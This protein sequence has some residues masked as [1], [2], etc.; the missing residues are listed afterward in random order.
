M[1]PVA[2]DMV[3]E[4]RYAVVLVEA[5]PEIVVLRLIKTVPTE[6]HERVRPHHHGRMDQLVPDEEVELRTS[7]L[8]IDLVARLVDEHDAA[9][10]QRDLRMG[11]EIG[12]L[13]LEPIGK[14]DVVRVHASD[15]RRRA[16]AQPALIATARPPGC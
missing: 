3:G 1:E 13:P 5:Q 11:I 9:A 8:P 14:H 16:S 15:Q 4:C 6:G 10:E 7:R 12:D 2:D